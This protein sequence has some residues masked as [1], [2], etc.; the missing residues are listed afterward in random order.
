MSIDALQNPKAWL[1][2]SN[3]GKKKPHF[4]EETLSKPVAH[5]NVTVGCC[6]KCPFYDKRENVILITFMRFVEPDPER[7]VATMKYI[8]TVLNERLFCWILNT[9]QN[10]TLKEK[11]QIFKSLYTVLFFSLSES[12]LTMP[13]TASSSI[14]PFN[15]ICDK[16]VTITLEGKPWITLVVFFFCVFRTNPWKSTRLCRWHLCIR[17]TKIRAIKYCWCGILLAHSTLCTWQKRE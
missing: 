8:H 10:T 15:F 1:W 4:K 3:G 7:A 12:F 17:W 13:H 9:G 16:Q 2:T 11:R 6:F 5:D 14:G